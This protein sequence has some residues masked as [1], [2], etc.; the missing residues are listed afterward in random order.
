MQRMIEDKLRV[1]NDYIDNAAVPVQMVPLANELGIRVYNAP[2]P[3][4]VSG[5]I[6]KDTKRGGKSGFACFVNERH[7]RVRRR[8]TIAH[9][10]AHYVLHEHLI[11]DGIYDD[12]LYRS[13]L[14]DRAETQ[15]NAMAAD[16]LMPWS[17]LN[18]YIAQH[19]DDVGALAEIFDVSRHAMSIRLGVPYHSDLER[20]PLEEYPEQARSVTLHSLLSEGPE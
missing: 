17:K 9:E 8:F 11:G 2:W 6:Q 10:V 20:T 15:A 1:V 5:K 4:S 18:E 16:L 19:G 14:P 12:A 13:G 7:P 3:N